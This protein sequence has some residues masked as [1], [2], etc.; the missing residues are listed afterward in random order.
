MALNTIRI[1]FLEK[2]RQEN[3]DDPFLMYALAQEYLQ[4]EPELSWNLFKTLLQQHPD[5]LPSYQAAAQFM[6]ERGY[7]D[8]AKAVIE[9]GIQLAK[10]QQNDKTAAELARLF[11]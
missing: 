6:I 11:A 9:K 4:D 2:E 3:P 5:Y 10:S 1:N 8:Q 7:K